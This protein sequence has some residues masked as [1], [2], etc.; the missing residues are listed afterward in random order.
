VATTISVVPAWKKTAWSDTKATAGIGEGTATLVVDAS[1]GRVTG[2][3][4][5]PLGPASIEG[6]ASDGTVSAT[7]RRKD[8]LDRGFAGTLVGSMA[9]DRLEG[10]MSLSLGQASAVRTAT[11]ALSR[12]PAPPGSR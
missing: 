3:L 5:G 10:T 1:T 11:F 9:N 12:E 7:V 8:P 4:D 6:A 2:D